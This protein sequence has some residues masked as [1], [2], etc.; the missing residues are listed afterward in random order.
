MIAQFHHPHKNLSRKWLI[1]VTWKHVFSLLFISNNGV[2]SIILYGNRSFTYLTA[3]T[4]HE[5]SSASPPFANNRR[6][7][8]FIFRISNTNY[9]NYKQQLFLTLSSAPE[10]YFICNISAAFLFKAGKHR[11]VFF[12]LRS[13][14]LVKFVIWTQE[15]H[16]APER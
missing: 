12:T 9:S 5:I 11:R 1:A 2:H 16:T 10:C 8:N 15:T 7:T 4:R 14:M 6:L 13:S 3:D